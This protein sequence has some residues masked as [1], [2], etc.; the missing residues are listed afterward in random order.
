MNRQQ[1]KFR[2]GIYL[3]AVIS[4]NESDKICQFVSILSLFLLFYRPFAFKNHLK[5]SFE[6]YIIHLIFTS[7]IQF[8]VAL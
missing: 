8:Y 2:C 7:D 1:F 6:N 5:L 4:S 3:F